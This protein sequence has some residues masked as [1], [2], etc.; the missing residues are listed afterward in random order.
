M[1]S[2]VLHAR[3][4]RS[5]ASELKFTIDAQLAA[6]IAA[7]ARA[8]LPPDPH[9]GGPFG[10]EY[11]VTSLYFDTPARDVLHGRGSFGRS[12]Y[13]VR[14]YGDSSHVFLE[15]KL[16]R[17][18]LLHKRRTLIELADLPWLRHGNT[19][20]GWAGRWFQRR[21]QARGL[22]PACAIRYA[23]IARVLPANGSTARLTID[24]RIE[25]CRADALAFPQGEPA[26]EL[27]DL[28]VLELKFRGDPPVVFKALLEEFGVSP[29]TTSKYR[30]G[31]AALENRP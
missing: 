12:K 25:V 30:R 31:M 1:S 6:R 27:G 26:R 19:P 17:P 13:R 29:T 23:R 10:D 22:S 4:T 14:R 20:A 18:G 3:E 5:G 24:D 21:M 28:V 11:A 16:R 2:A 8:R 9:G 15:R 7:W